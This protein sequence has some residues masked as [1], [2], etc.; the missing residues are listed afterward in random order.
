MTATPHTL[1]ICVNCQKR[2]A[3]LTWVGEGGVL[4]LPDMPVTVAISTESAETLDNSTVPSR[5]AAQAQE[6]P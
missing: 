4:A 1:G 5:L 6:K 2:P 3:T